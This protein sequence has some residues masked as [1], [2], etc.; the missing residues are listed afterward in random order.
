[1]RRCSSFPLRRRASPHLRLTPCRYGDFSETASTV[2]E[3]DDPRKPRY[4]RRLEGISASWTPAKMVKKITK[5]QKRDPDTK[6]PILEKIEEHRKAGFGFI[7]VLRALAHVG[8]PD[9]II[10]LGDE[11]CNEKVKPTEVCLAFCCALYSL[12][13][14]VLP[15]VLR[16]KPS[17]CA[18]LLT[19]LGPVPRRFSSSRPISTA[20][21]ARNATQNASAQSSSVELRR[22]VRTVL[23]RLDFGAASAK[24]QSHSVCPS[25][26]SVAP[27]S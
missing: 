26:P 8:L 24:R 4:W 10:S 18:F 7:R 11:R 5:V 25:P 12:G 1:M 17:C 2:D 19:D 13:S 21:K 22:A 23:P 9:E 16:G 6:K 20:R 3:N 14:N 15:A 27:S